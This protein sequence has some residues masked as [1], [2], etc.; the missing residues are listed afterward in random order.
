MYFQWQK[1][2]CLTF[3]S[4]SG[5]ITTEILV[6]VL[7]H[8]DEKEVFPYI[9]GGPI[10]F[11]IVDGHNTCLDP[12]FIDYINDKGHCWKVF[13]GVPYATSLWQVRDSAQN[14]GSFKM[15]WYLVKDEL[16]VWK[17]ERGWIMSSGIM[18]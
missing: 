15:E 7:K 16:M 5:G 8:F 14:N 12:L 3:C 4:D 10:Q 13:L 11:L 9:P 2:N 18:T 1:I 6:K 17:Y